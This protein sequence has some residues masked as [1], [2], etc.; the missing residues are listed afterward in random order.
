MMISHVRSEPYFDHAYL[1]ADIEFTPPPGAQ[2][3]EFVLVD[4]AVTH[5]VRNHVVVV[6]RDGAE[7]PLLG[8]LQYP[9]TR[10]A[11]SKLPLEAE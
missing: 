3:R 9:A 7:N 2:S 4:D 11:V 5:E 10:L 6:T 1:I 8:A